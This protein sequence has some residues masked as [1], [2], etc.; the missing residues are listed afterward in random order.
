MKKVLITGSGG[1]IGRH[2]VETA[3]KETGWEIH[4][5]VSGTRI[6]DFPEKV[7]V[8]TADLSSAPECERLM[9]TVKPEIVL[10]LAWELGGKGYQRSVTNLVWVENSLRLLRLFFQFGGRRFVFAGTGAEYDQFGGRSLEKAVQIER[11]LYGEGKRAF[12]QLAKNYCGNNNFE[13]ASA[14]IFSVY[15]ENDYRKNL[16]AVASAIQCF[17]KGEVF[18]CKTPNNVWDFIH[19]TDVAG[20]LVKIA[21]SDYCG[22]VNVGTGKPCLVRDV[23]A[24]ISRI[25]GCQSLLYFEENRENISMLVA[26]PTILNSTIGYKCN[27]ELSDGL[28]RTIAWWQG[29]G[30]S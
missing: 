4:A 27:V 2:T 1:F 22:T 11:T 12:E 26:N 9:E 25:M 10:H 13:F 14:R 18:T 29:R 28:D 24:E 30:N 7:H 5:V 17:K 16:S 8:H 23:F 20:A 3:A 19:V 6:H 15:G 21:S